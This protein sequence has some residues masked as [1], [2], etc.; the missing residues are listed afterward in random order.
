MSAFRKACVGAAAL[1]AV[2]MTAGSADA[3]V[4]SFSRITDN[5]HQNAAGQ[6]SVD[7]TSG[8]SGTLFKFM[9]S[10]AIASSITD[11]YFDDTAAF[12]L[13]NNFS[14]VDSLGV[15]SFG[16][17]ASPPNL[18]GGKAISFVSDF[19]AESNRPVSAKGINPAEYLTILFSGASYSA[20]MAHI[21]DGLLRI[22][23]HVQSIG[24]DGDS[25]SFVSNRPVVS[26]PPVVVVPP[27]EAEDDH[28]HHDDKPPVVNTPVKEIPE[29]MSLVLMGAGVMG[30][31]LARRRR[32]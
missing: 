13:S 8:A 4:L 30:L 18:P 32:S 12:V 29:P 26:P 15:V 9:N 16:A 10:G 3:A 20:V 6:L 11:I 27:K 28:P 21:N 24:H 19:S 25:D 5:S 31:G 2:S 17:G 1:L 23:L 14:F 7:V 22:G